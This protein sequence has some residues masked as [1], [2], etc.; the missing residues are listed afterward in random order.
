MEIQ[1]YNDGMTELTS[2]HPLKKVLKISPSGI[3][4]FT[5]ET[6]KWYAETYHKDKVKLSSTALLMGT[7]VHFVLEHYETFLT[8]PERVRKAIT[9]YVYLET[10]DMNRELFIEQCISYGRKGVDAIIANQDTE[11]ILEREQFIAT[12]LYEGEDLVIYVGGSFDALVQTK[13][14]DTVTVRDYKTTSRKMSII[15][16]AYMLQAY[17]YAFLVEKELN[18]KV[19]G[20]DNFYLIKRTKTIQERQETINGAY[21]EPHKNFIKS[22]LAHITESLV[23][24]HSLTTAQQGLHRQDIPILV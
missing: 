12:K 10:L 4:K 9:E 24:Y 3:G 22:Y 19:S 13:Y 21:A 11:T 1:Q 5:S 15:P 17:T 16:R 8:D 2:R 14:T 7:C 18:Y 23:Y 6:N 20:V